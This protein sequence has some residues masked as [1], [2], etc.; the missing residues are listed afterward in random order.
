LAS[1][2][3]Q[4]SFGVEMQVYCRVLMNSAWVGADSPDD[5]SVSGCGVFYWPAQNTPDLALF[6]AGKALR[7]LAGLAAAP[8][9]RNTHAF[10]TKLIVQRIEFRSAGW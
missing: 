1:Q 10:K 5:P 8:G 2:S 9:N 4:L 7:L 3:I 6:I